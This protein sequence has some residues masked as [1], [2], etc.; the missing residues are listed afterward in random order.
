VDIP[1]RGDAAYEGSF[2]VDT[3]G[4][5]LVLASWPGRRVLSFRIEG[6]GD[7][8]LRLQRSGPPPQRLHI[9]VGE[10][11]IAAGREWKLFVRALPDRGAVRASVVL[12]LPERPD[13]VPP[14]PPL[15]DVSAPPPPAALIEPWLASRG[16]PSGAPEGVT[17]MFDA[18]ERFRV[19]VVSSQGEL[20]PD[21]CAWQAPFLKHAASI[22]DDAAASASGA[23]AER[24]CFE[25]IADA[26]RRVEALRVSAD[27]V[28]V[29]R[30]P[31]DPLERLAWRS[32]R[33]ELIRPLEQEL[34]DLQQAARD[35]RCPR[36]EENWPGRL[37][38][39]LTACERHFDERTRLGDDEAVNGHLVRDQWAR[40]LA[41]GQVLE[42]ILGAP[43]AGAGSSAAPPP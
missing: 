23:G 19:T 32:R 22:R 26:I 41:A 18:V 16:A 13:P 20:L 35:G 7:P 1:D 43:G 11:T 14:E 8:P 25:R 4:D 28:L 2:Q 29:G 37:V 21:P 9:D 31:A 12:D 30:A 34:D 10:E 42:A 5:L 6:P 40:I 39:C 27:P 3:P 24:R 33:N 15:P 36:L 17:R 38:A